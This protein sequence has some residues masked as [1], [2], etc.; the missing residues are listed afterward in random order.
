MILSGDIGGTKTRL[1]LFEREN[2]SLIRK[3]VETCPSQEYASLEHILRTFLNEH[4]VSVEKA[5]L[6][7]PGPVV[8]GE[9]QT[10]NLPWRIKELDLK[11]ASGI[12]GLKLV[13]DLV[14][15]AAAIPHLADTDLFTLH[16]GKK[17]S[18]VEMKYGIL[19][20]GTGLGQAFLLIND[21]DES[22]VLASE[23]GHVDFAPRSDLE[24]ELLQYLKSKFK[25]VS[26]ER[27][28][29]GPGLQNIY[30]FLKDKGYA[31]E[32]PE[33]T[34]RL[35]REDPGAV[36]SSTGQ[37]GEYKL[38]IKA[39]D[40]FAAILGAQASNM[41]LTFLAIGGIY[42]G[43]GIPPKICKKLK[44]GTTVAAFLD[45]GRL[46]H[47]VEDTPLYVI[48]DD[49]AAILGAASLASRL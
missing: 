18:A 47:L 15:T 49:H 40:I 34:E 35:R 42:L 29:S 2:D 8:D 27:V 31:E 20:P 36:I 5:C 26:Y 3:K 16:E 19:A 12:S 1:A 24:V 9:A 41:V 23:G 11:K 46:S 10:T 4:N 25:R 6:G 22:H 21:A 38:C 17:H 45:K 14:A 32:P 39:L 33:L 30:Q 7:V 48:Q 44:D 28:L 37:S 43:G 13:N